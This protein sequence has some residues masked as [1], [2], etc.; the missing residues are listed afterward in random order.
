[1]AHT[2][3]LMVAYA[4]TINAYKRY[5]SQS[6]APTRL[7]WS[8]DNR[9]TSFRIV[10]RGQ[11]RRI[12]CRLPGA[13]ANPYL[14]YA[15]ALASGLDGIEQRIEP[16]AELVGDAYASDA[17]HVPTTLAAATERVGNSEAARR[18]LGNDVVDHYDH[19]HR[20]E[21]AAFNAAVTDWEHRRY[22]ERI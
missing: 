2:P 19:F 1:M 22:F 13:D 20:S 3:D 5:Q 21:V 17:D 11:S 9:T 8:T 7:A 4:P 14:A 18:L 16:P 6:W 10:G 15:A 12:E